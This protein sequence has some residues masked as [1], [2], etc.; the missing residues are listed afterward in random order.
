MDKM[1]EEIATVYNMSIK[2]LYAKFEELYGFPPGQTSIVTIRNRIIYRIQEIY[3]DGV[4]VED[5]MFLQSL[6]VNDPMAHLIRKPTSRVSKTVGARYTRL[7]KGKKY[8]VVVLG[9]DK[10]EMSGKV[11]ASLSAVARAITG[12]RWNGKL[13]FGVK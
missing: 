3:L 12:T 4:D 13:F 8:E 5:R 2:E 1:S 7:W 11:Y 9:E 10:F 6:I